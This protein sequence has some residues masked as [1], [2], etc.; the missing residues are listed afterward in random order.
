MLYLVWDGKRGA[1]Q[2]VL[3][4]FVLEYVINKLQDSQ[5]ELELNGT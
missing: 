3:S 5:Q 1:L 4:M 2:P